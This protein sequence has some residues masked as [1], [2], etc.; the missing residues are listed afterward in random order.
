[1]ATDPV[2]DP[3]AVDGG[4]GVTDSGADLTMQCAD[5][6]GEVARQN[7][8]TEGVEVVDLSGGEHG[9]LLRPDPQG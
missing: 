5:T 7:D 9:S 6:V 2:D 8:E 3:L 4:E 1:V